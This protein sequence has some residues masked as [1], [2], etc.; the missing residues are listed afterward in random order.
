MLL[1]IKQLWKLYQITAYNLYLP[2][3]NTLSVSQNVLLN[4]LN[5]NV[6]ANLHK[7]CDIL[8]FVLFQG[9]G[10]QKTK[11]FMSTKVKDVTKFNFCGPKG[12]GHLGFL[13]Y[14]SR[15]KTGLKTP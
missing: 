2:Y 14:R 11:I 4:P 3:L 6:L 1:K 15:T 12:E 5:T 13:F 10:H 7:I 8:I 9:Q